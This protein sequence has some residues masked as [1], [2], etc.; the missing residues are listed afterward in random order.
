MSP[1]HDV[2]LFRAQIVRYRK[3]RNCF[4]SCLL[5]EDLAGMVD[6]S[7]KLFLY[8][9]KFNMELNFNGFTVSGR[10]VKLKSVNWMEIYYISPRHK[11][12][13]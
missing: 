3:D 8:G 9:K 5:I 4:R 12:Q 10:I 6:I 7:S 13:H 11:A 2:Y 1:D